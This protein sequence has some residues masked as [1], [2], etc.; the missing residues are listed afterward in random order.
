MAGVSRA[1][2]LSGRIWRC[3][4]ASTTNLVAPF[5]TV[6]TSELKPPLE[7]AKYIAEVG[8]T[9]QPPVSNKM[10]FGDGFLKVMIVGGPNARM[11]YH[12]QVLSQHAWFAVRSGLQSLVWLW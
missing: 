2:R 11:D 7:F 4:I 12:L 10:L 3:P 9:L 1:L 6:I 5:S 8:P